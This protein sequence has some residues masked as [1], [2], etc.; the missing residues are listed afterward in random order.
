VFGL[1]WAGVVAAVCALPLTVGGSVRADSAG[2]GVEARAQ[3]APGARFSWPAV[4]D[5]G[6]N[7]SRAVATDLNA[8]GAPDL[9]TVNWTS[10]TVS[11]LIGRGDGTFRRQVAYRA[12]RRPIGLAASDVSGDGHP[13]LITASRDRAGSISLFLNHGPGRFH[14]ARTYAVGRSANA[15]AAADINQ[16]GIVDLVTALDSRKNFA[17]LLGQGAGRFRVAHRYNGAPAFDVAVGDLNG[18]GKV[19]V[20][21]ASGSVRFGH[22]DGTFGPAHEYWRDADFFGV[23]AADLNQDDK[24]DIAGASCPAFRRCE[25]G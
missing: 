8:D 14:R 15:V 2:T 17:V 4:L 18:D 1:R 23:T 21:L 12:A 6:A 20:V 16:D 3:A 9:A 5:V 25:R 10:A 22:G 13:D 19:D 7:P 11:V 24:L